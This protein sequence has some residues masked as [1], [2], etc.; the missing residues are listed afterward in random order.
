MTA[1]HLHAGIGFALRRIGSR[2]RIMRVDRLV[3][4]SV[5]GSVLLVWL[6][7][8]GID[9]FRT[10]VGEVNDVGKGSYTLGGAMIYV[11][12]TAPRRAYEWFGYAAL[13]GGLLG[14]GGLAAT[15]ELTALRAAGLSKL[16]IS[17]SV[18]LTLLVMTIAVTFN[19]ETLGP[20]GDNQAQAIALAAK[21]S[22]V[23]LAS[24]GSL[25]ARDGETIVNARRAITRA[26]TDGGSEIE[27]YG[28]RIFEFDAMGKL[29]ALSLAE[30]ATQIGRDWTLH[31]LRRTDFGESDAVSTSVAEQ[32]WQS[33][34]DPRLLA[35]SIIRTGYMSASDL[36]RSIRYMDRNKQDA[37]KYRNAFW[38]RVYYPINVLLLAFCAMPFAFGSLRSGGAARRLFMGLVL[39]ITFYL[40]KTSIVSFATIYGMHAVLANA[41]PPLILLTGIVIY[42]KRHA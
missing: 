37:S 16:R 14:L 18:V 38:E 11:L 35:S 15:G 4:G 3:A 9:L 32:A 12:L 10:L 8:I 7:L 36:Q 6:V 39:A 17:A 20:L 23:A 34:L 33:K 42:F 24:G 21:S 27:M 28:V 41:I 19:G 31:G 1:E 26:R 5:I 25:W 2:L 30:R 40:M 29:K 22:D 13:I